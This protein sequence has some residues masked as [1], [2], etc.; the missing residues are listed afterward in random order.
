MYFPTS[1]L[2]TY[3]I[4]KNTCK[5]L[6]PCNITDIYKQHNGTNQFTTETYPCTKMNK[7]CIHKS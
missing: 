3:G 7:H 5:L 6:T 1:I 4:F 2:N